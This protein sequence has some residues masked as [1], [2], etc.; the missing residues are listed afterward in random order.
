MP[1]SAGVSKDSNVRTNR[2]SSTEP[3]VGMSKRKV[4]RRNVCQ[5]LA[6]DIIADSSREGSMD[7]N[8]A[9]ISRKARGT[10]PTECTQIIPGKENTLNGGDLRPNRFVSRSEERRVGKECR[11]R[12]ATTD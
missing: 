10:C 6:P 12:W 11:S 4:T 9:T 5:V 1:I 3:A 8:A 2:I 7:L